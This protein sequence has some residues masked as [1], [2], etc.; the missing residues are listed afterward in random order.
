M[1]VT[2]VK[3]KG[4]KSVKKTNGESGLKKRVVS[5]RQKKRSK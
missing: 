5:K 3:P 1:E 4:T 2:G